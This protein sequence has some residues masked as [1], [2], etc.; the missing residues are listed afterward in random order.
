[1]M[2]CFKLR[3]VTVYTCNY[4]CSFARVEEK[5]SLVSLGLGK[6][7]DPSMSHRW[8]KPRPFPHGLGRGQGFSHCGR[9]SPLDTE[10]WRGSGENRFYTQ[11][12]LHPPHLFFDRFHRLGFNH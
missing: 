2:F 12:F 4:K 8:P 9:W 6:G 7:Q 1:M 3:G 5:E 10:C 11:T